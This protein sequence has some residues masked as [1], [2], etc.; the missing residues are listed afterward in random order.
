MMGMSQQKK[1]II[2]QRLTSSVSIFLISPYF[3]TNTVPRA[4]MP[5]TT[6]DQPMISHLKKSDKKR[7]SILND[8]WSINNYQFKNL[9][10]YDPLIIGHGLLPEVKFS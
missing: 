1:A 2:K 3:T 8:Q 5:T 10:I 4:A 7:T 9:A 6:I